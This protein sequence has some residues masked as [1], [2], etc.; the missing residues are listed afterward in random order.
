MPSR[1]R[2]KHIRETAA[3]F[4]DQALRYERS[5]TVRRFQSRAQAILLSQLGFRPGMRVLD[6]GCGAGTATLAIAPEL[7]KCG[8]VVGVD[9]SP[10]MI[11]E[12]EWKH[13]RL[14]LTGVSFAVGC[15]EELAEQSAFDVVVCTNASHHFRDKRDIFRRVLSALRPGGR[16]AI[17][18]I[19]DE[20]STMRILDRLGQLGE[21]AHVDSTGS[22]ELRQLME[23][24]GSEQ[25]KAD[26]VRVTWF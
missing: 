18:D 25:V 10:K 20:A 13:E 8:E 6:L 21:R 14:G 9:A 26:R 19:C 11:A 15:A 1:E 17:E 16:F 12:A 5:C 2:D 4:G 3:H 7:G 23:D 24:A 22:M